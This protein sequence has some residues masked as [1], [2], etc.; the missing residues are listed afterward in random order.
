MRV[1]VSN[2]NRSQCINNNSSQLSSKTIK[3]PKTQKKTDF[4]LSDG[5][6]KMI[7]NYSSCWNIHFAD[8]VYNTDKD[9]TFKVRVLNTGS[10]FDHHYIGFTN[11][12]YSNDCLCLYKPNAWY[13]HNSGDNFKEANKIKFSNI[14]M[15]MEAGV[16]KIYQFTPDYRVIYNHKTIVNQTELVKFSKEISEKL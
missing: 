14:K 9:V 1:Q 15:S 3:W 6:K 16:P 8:T 5:D 11:S 7:V 10:K 12:I 4:T 13:I 2:S